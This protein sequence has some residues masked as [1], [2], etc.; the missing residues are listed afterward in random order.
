MNITIGTCSLCG[1]RVTVPEAWAG[2]NPPVPTCE[3]CGATAKH[4]HG[5]VIDMDH[6]ST[7]CTPPEL[8]SRTYGCPNRGSCFCTGVCKP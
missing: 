8:P 6:L 4:P 5:R 1:G 7:P 3:L 2:M